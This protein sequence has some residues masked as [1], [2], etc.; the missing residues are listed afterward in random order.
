MMEGGAGRTLRAVEHGE[1][2][3]RGGHVGVV[4]AEAPLEDGRRAHE[5]RRRLVVLLQPAL[6][7]PGRSSAEGFAPGRKEGGGA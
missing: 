2:V 5:E 6:R 4:A 3:E 7:G 1:V